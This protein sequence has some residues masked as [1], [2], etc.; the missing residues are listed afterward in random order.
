[1][2]KALLKILVDDGFPKYFFMKLTVEVCIDG[3]LFVM[4]SAMKGIVDNI[5]SIFE[6]FNGDFFGL[7]DHAFEYN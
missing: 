4:Q 2:S 1:M 5:L 6:H 3:N 7:N